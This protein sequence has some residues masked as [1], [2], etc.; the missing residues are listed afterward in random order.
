MSPPWRLEGKSIDANINKT[1]DASLE[2]DYEK[3]FYKYG[4][5]NE[6]PGVTPIMKDHNALGHIK[7][8]T[9]LPSKSY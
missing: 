6:S 9:E 4:N 2:G 7:T 5:K 1:F 8:S 3:Y